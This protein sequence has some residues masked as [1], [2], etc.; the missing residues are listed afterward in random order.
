MKKHLLIL[1]ASGQLGSALSNTSLWPKDY[2]ITALT[3]A[4]LDIR[5][6]TALQCLF[7]EK[8]PFQAVI[9]ASVFMPVDLCEKFPELGFQTNGFSL[10]PLATLCKMHETLLVHFSTDYVFDG[11]KKTPYTQLN[12]NYGFNW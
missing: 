1:G 5:D 4:Q 3:H 8:G 11:L 2:K 7:K 10:L 12:S 6:S 9:N